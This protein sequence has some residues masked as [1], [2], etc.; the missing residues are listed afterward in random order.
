MTNNNNRVVI[1]YN[2]LG[3]SVHFSP[4]FLYS[5][6][7]GNTQF[8]VSLLEE[9]E[10]KFISL[11]VKFDHVTLIRHHYFTL[12]HFVCAILPVHRLHE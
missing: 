5:A 8:S 11:R 7:P 6:V 10:A 2:K 1:I 9:C 3:C 4:F 12:L